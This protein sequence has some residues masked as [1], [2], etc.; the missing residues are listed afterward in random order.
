METQNMEA[1]K[2]CVIAGALLLAFMLGR[3]S[4]DQSPASAKAEA[5]RARSG[6]VE[7]SDVTVQQLQ[8]VLNQNRQMTNLR[9]EEALSNYI[10][11][12][13][14]WKGTLKSA[15]SSEGEL[16]GVISHRIKPSWLLGQR[17]VQVTVNF[18]DSQKETL[19]NAQKGS[20]VTYQGVLSEYMGSTKRPWLLTDGQILSV[21]IIQP[22]VKA[23]SKSPS[24]QSN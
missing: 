21:E 19:L 23:K 10:N 11:K 12:Q 13:V 14:Q 17:Q 8:E 6:K 3:W 24:Q 9:R 1:K 16:W 18:A 5:Q 2:Y 7:Q 15:Y 20:L 4:A 22:K